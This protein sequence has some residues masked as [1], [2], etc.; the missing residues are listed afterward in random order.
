MKPQY[1]TYYGNS[2]QTPTQLIVRRHQTEESAVEYYRRKIATI[3]GDGYSH[4]YGLVELADHDESEPSAPTRDM[5][6]TVVEVGDKLDDYE[7]YAAWSDADGMF[8]P[9]E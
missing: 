1:V 5:Q 2:C 4:G 8:C 9:V 6:F 3:A 7:L